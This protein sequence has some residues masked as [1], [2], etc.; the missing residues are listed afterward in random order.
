MLVT[1][2]VLVYWYDIGRFRDQSSFSFRRSRGG[3][4]FLLNFTVGDRCSGRFLG[5]AN[6]VVLFLLGDGR[7]AARGDVGVGRGA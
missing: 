6:H 4:L 2:L 1:R 7:G 3:S 5:N